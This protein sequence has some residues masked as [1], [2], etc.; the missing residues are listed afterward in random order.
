MTFEPAETELHAAVV[1]LQDETPEDTEFFTVDLVNPQDGAEVGP[2]SSL[3]IS[4]LSNDNA[5]GVIE[6][7]AVSLSVS[8]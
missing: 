8:D 7:A 6:F 2:Q 1:V 4:I 3:N 5:H